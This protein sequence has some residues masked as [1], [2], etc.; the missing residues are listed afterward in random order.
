[1]FQSAHP[2]GVRLKNRRGHDTVT[3]VSI[4]APA[5]GATY[6]G[7][8]TTNYWCFNPRTRMGCDRTPLLRA[9]KQE[10]F[11]SAHPHGVRQV[12][13][14]PD[15]HNLYVSIRA[16][17]WGATADA[18]IIADGT[19][20][21]IR[22]PAWGATLNWGAGDIKTERFNP[23]T[24]MGCDGS[25][26]VYGRYHRSFNPRTRMGCDTT[27]SGVFDGPFYVSIRAPAWG[28]T[29]GNAVLD[30]DKLVSIRAPAW[31]ATHPRRK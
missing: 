16:P 22:A 9:S 29:F 18:V 23:R 20:V 4:R 26:Y 2:H 6:T 13:G 12:A 24:R 3:I 10:P 19:M 1:M 17:A 5:W 11:Q 28:A 15:G 7:R 8:G 30:T 25:L 27:A 21:S 14:N 31:G